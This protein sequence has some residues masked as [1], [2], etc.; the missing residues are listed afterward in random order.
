MKTAVSVPDDVFRAG[1]RVARRLG[2]SRSGLYSRALRE[3][4]DLRDEDEITRRLNE[5]YE[6][7]AASVD[8]A[9]SRIAGIGRPQD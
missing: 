3:F 6:R 9:M 7:E 1:E 8:P 5:V 4:L 2:L